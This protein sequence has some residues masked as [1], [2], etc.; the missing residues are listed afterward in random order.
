[1]MT[2]HWFVGA[3]CYSLVFAPLTGWAQKAGPPVS[4]P[5]KNYGYVTPSDSARTAEADALREG[6][7]LM[8]VLFLGALSQGIHYFPE[9]TDLLTCIMYTSGY[10]ENADLNGITIRRKGVKD[11]IFVD[12]EDLIADGA[13]IPTLKDG[14]IVTVNWSWRRD[15]QMYYTLTGFI[16]SVTGLVI[17]IVALTK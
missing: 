8:R 4:A 12:L 5:A 16:T 7:L 1:M 11:L 3:L 15:L 10:D 6:K 14:D 2:R 13:E 9:E 17:S